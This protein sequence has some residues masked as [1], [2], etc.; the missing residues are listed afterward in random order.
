MFSKFVK[1]FFLLL[2]LL[3]LGLGIF[4]SKVNAEV[5]CGEAW[6]TEQYPDGTCGTYGQAGTMEPCLHPDGYCYDPMASV[7]CHI[8]INGDCGQ[9]PGALTPTP[10]R[11][12]GERTPTPTP[13]PTPP[14]QDICRSLNCQV[15]P[16][17]CKDTSL[18]EGQ[19]VDLVSVSTQPVRE[20]RYALYN[21][22]NLYPA[23][24]AD[25][26]K[27]ICVPPDFPGDIN[28]PTDAC[29]PNTYHLVYRKIYSSHQ[30]KGTISLNYDQ[31]FVPDQLN[32]GNIPS[33]VS[34]TAYMVDQNGQL[35]NPVEPCVKRLA[36]AII[37]ITPTPTPTL[38]I[39]PTPP[40]KTPTPFPQ[41][42][43]TRIDTYVDGILIKPGS[44]I[45]VGQY[46]GFKA[47][48][49]AKNTIITGMIFRLRHKESGKIV[50]SQ[51]VL[52]SYD[53]DARMYV[54]NTTPFPKSYKIITKGSYQ[55]SASMIKR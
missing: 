8:T 44:Q 49:I 21:M 41:V 33:K 36:R 54:G 11:P 4:T 52:A 10:T 51:T 7:K 25:N 18:S 3:I 53:R 27:P 37:T 5:V 47:W 16:T 15:G 17:L 50:F 13:T 32:G 30:L 35:S 39:T 31:I 55:I 40:K 22:D 38:T 12:P 24:P 20:F 46:V 28:H 26:P 2:L 29:P 6:R 34:F 9:G 43:C 45:K 1:T 42:F 23:P 19:R 48:G 14:R